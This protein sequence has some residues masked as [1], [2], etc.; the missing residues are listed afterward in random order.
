MPRRLSTSPTVA[1]RS[2]ESAVYANFH[3]GLK[4]LWV[5]QNGTVISI[6]V[7][8]A[9]EGGATAAQTQATLTKVAF[10]AL[11]RL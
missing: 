5:W 9:D 1:S 11:G 6:S 2:P 3:A 4:A 7:S 10:I 8:I